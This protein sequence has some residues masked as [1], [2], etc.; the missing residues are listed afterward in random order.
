MNATTMGGATL[1][2]HAWICMG[3][4]DGHEGRD[5]ANAAPQPVPCRLLTQVKTDRVS[6]SSGDSLCVAF[7]DRE[8]L[9]NLFAVFL[10][11]RLCFLG[12]WC[13]IAAGSA[14]AAVICTPTL[15]RGFGAVVEDDVL[16][17]LAVP[18][19]SVD[20]VRWSAVC[21]GGSRGATTT[22]RAGSTGPAGGEIACKTM[23]Q[24]KSKKIKKST[25][26]KYLSTA[27]KMPVDIPA[28]TDLI[29]YRQGVP[30][31]S[32]TDACRQICTDRTH[33]LLAR[34]DIVC[35][36]CKKQGHMRGECPELKKKLK[37]EKFTFKKAK[38]MLATWS[39]EDEDED[40]QEASGDEEIQCTMMEM[41]KICSENKMLNLK[42]IH[43]RKS[44]KMKLLKHTL[45]QNNL[46][47]INFHKSKINSALQ[48]SIM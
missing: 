34:S 9:G 7:S 29:G 6:S 30:F 25:K 37:K 48:Q 15:A 1:K 36:E 13:P 41:T 46:H 17:T 33:R 2:P 27:P 23:Y 4:R 3:C 40:A 42:K 11:L 22:D 14:A 8:G 44:L 45:L 19:V 10:R 16:G 26:D 38:V 31:D 43:K 35:Y 39:D 32:P 24:N 5:K 28:Q 12:T 20:A 18:V 21:R 47:K